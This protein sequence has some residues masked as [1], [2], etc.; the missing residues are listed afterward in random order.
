[1]VS[2][3]VCALSAVTLGEGDGLLEII[4][5]VHKPVGLLPFRS[6]ESDSCSLQVVRHHVVGSVVRGQAERSS[7]TVD[8]RREA[9]SITVNKAVNATA[10][11]KLVSCHAHSHILTFFDRTNLIDSSYEDGT[12]RTPAYKDRVNIRIDIDVTVFTACNADLALRPILLYEL[13]IG[14]DH[15]ALV[16]L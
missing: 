3:Y 10:D 9:R 6:I 16:Q 1:V 5:V 13:L 2:R 4:D 8:D 12:V 11:S 15:H 14:I 7:I